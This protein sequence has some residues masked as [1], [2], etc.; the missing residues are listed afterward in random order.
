M[1]QPGNQRSVK[2]FNTALQVQDTHTVRPVG[3]T[4]RCLTEALRLV[5]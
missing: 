1:P 2:F 4:Q 5:T 3:Q